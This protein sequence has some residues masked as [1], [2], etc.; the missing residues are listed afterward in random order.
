MFK[1]AITFLTSAFPVLC[2]ASSISNID[3]FIHPYIGIGPGLNMRFFQSDYL[4]FVSNTYH[5]VNYGNF[6]ASGQLH[7]GYNRGFNSNSVIG[8]DVHAQHNGTSA[9][10]HSHDNI[11][12]YHS[13]QMP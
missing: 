4:D 3:P 6:G 2:M 12:A 10:V 9:S 8:L 11:P 1:K 13:N 5:V 7:A